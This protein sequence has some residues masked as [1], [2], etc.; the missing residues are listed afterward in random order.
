MSRGGHRL[1]RML[2]PSSR[3]RTCNVEGWR[4]GSPHSGPPLGGGGPERPEALRHRWLCFGE[5]NYTR[6]QPLFPHLVGL[7]LEVI[8]IFVRKVGKTALAVQILTHG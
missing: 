8:D 2:G 1:E 4:L 7:G 6:H 5:G 3:R